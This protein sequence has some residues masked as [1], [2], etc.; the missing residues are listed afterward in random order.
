MSLQLDSLPQLVA[1]FINNTNQNIFLTGKAGTGKTT[2]LRNITKYT[3]KSVIVAAPTGIAAINAGGVTL[4]SLFQLPFGAFIP[5]NNGLNS[6]S[7]STQINTPRTLLSSFQMHKTK[8]NMLKKMELLIIDEVSM[9]RADLLDAIDLILRSVRRERDL[10]FGGVQVLFIGDLLQL[11][12][13]VK[14]DEWRV[15]G[16]YYPSAFFFSAQVL[17]QMPPLYV[18]LEK[19]YR[20]SDDTFIKLLNNLRN[21]IVTAEDANLLNKYYKPSYQQ[22]SDE[23]VILLTTHNRIANDKNLKALQGIKESSV[24]FKAEVIGDFKEFSYP[25]DES[26]ELKKGAQ[27]MFTK[28]D[29]SGE[30]KYFN[31]KIGTITKL[32]REQIE[33]SFSDGSESAIA[34]QYLWENKKYSVD[35]DSNEI[36]ESIVGTFKQYPLKLAWAITV[37][38]SQ[39]LT[40][41]KA[42]IDVQNAFAPGQIYVALSRLRS[43]DG[44]ILTSPIPTEGFQVDPSLKSFSE[45]KK[46]PEELIPILKSESQNYFKS[47]VLHAFDFAGLMQDLSYHISTYN[48]DAKKSIKQQHKSKAL[49]W[50]ENTQPIRTVADSFRAEVNRIVTEGS[51]NYQLHLLERI[52]KAAAYFEPL[53]KTI[54]DDIRELCNELKGTKGAKAYHTEL[55]DLSNLYYGQLQLVYKAQTLIKTAIDGTDFDRN[56]IKKPSFAESRENLSPVNKKRTPKEKKEKVDTKQ[57]SFEMYKESKNIKA[58]AKERSL[59]EGTVEGHLAHYVQL[60]E[61]DVLDFIGQG[62]LS[63]IEKAIH[64][65]DTF[66]LTPLK[67]ELGKEFSF[68]ELRLGVAYMISQNKV[69]NSD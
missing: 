4:H 51:K 48:K 13:V 35:K 5:D 6:Q 19:I 68:G 15:I 27:V 1:K 26:L 44:L 42:I 20:Q 36:E 65:L 32:N 45:I 33:V 29:Y 25:T 38:K 28:N 43:L 60:G 46:Q 16:A 56:S 24:F 66:A 69:D 54:H 23:G 10:P 37:H 7:M 11:P 52:N 8:R 31:G 55:I 49:A 14:E 58:I 17:R 39:G 50:L 3:H 34:E 47:F 2:F 22:K 30:Q 63:M 64:S 40:F 67:K 21:N 62:K 9:L 59:T 12:P 57:V 18:E 53:I 61:L 41:D